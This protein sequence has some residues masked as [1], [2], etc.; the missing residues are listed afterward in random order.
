VNPCSWGLN[1][2]YGRQDDKK[3]QYFGS[4]V[5]AESRTLPVP[6]FAPQIADI[7][8]VDHDLR[9]KKLAT[10]HL[11]LSTNPGYVFSNAGKAGSILI[12]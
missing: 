9:R 11:T 6:L 8:P 12:S 1:T 2:H 4:D 10:Y 5:P 7:L 3:T